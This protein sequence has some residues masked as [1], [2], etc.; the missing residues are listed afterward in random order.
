M[1]EWKPCDK[2]QSKMIS[3]SGKNIHTVEIHVCHERNNSERSSSTPDRKFLTGYGTMWKNMSEETWNVLDPDEYVKH[4][5]FMGYTNM[6][7]EKIS[8]ECS[9][10]SMKITHGVTNLMGMVHGGMLYALADVVT[11]LT[12]RADGRKYVT[13]SAHINFIR[14]VSEGTV[15]AKGILIR[16]GRSITIV[17]SEVTDEKGNLLA[18]VT[19]DMFCLGE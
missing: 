19:V 7:I 15:Y 11:G 5:P 2:I 9:E 14:N 10:I 13:Q 8:P 16:R 3:R 18:D 1:H 17:R 12:A 6:K 4:N